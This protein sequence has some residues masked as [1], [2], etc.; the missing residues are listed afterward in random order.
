MRNEFSGRLL[1]SLLP[2]FIDSLLHDL[3]RLWMNIVCPHKKA[4]GVHEETPPNF[5][6]FR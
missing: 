5:V 3:P 1:F 6:R 4:G 2:F